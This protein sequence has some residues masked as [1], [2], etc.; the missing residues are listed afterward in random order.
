MK[1]QTQEVGVLAWEYMTHMCWNSIQTF[2]L[3]PCPEK[4]A[5]DM[6][7]EDTQ[8]S[9]EG[10]LIMPFLL[11]CDQVTHSE[12]QDSQQQKTRAHPEMP[13]FFPGMLELLRWEDC[14]RN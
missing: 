5:W 6:A 12:Q 9:H 3:H 13:K 11:H 10:S 7:V 8:V 4:L 14:S 2:S 1:G